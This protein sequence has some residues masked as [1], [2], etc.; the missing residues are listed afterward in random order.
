MN[1]TLSV[2]LSPLL[3]LTGVITQGVLP[4]VHAAVGATSESITASWKS[5]VLQAG[6]KGGLYAAER[7]AYAGAIGWKYTGDFSAVVSANYAPAS[8]IEEGRPARDLKAMLNTSQKVR[9]SKAGKRYLII[10][11]RHTLASMPSAVSGAAISMGPSW[12]TG[13]AF[14]DNGM[15]ASVLRNT[16]HWDKAGDQFKKGKKTY[17]SIGALPAGLAPKLKPSHKTDIYA[18]MRRMDTSSGKSKSSAY[19]T[20]RVMVEGSNG[21]VIPARPGLFIADAVAKNA[22]ASFEANVSEALKVI[23]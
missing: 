18:G 22:E 19:L 23:G 9:M 13:K 12:I 6:G 15:G 20:F 4:A 3:G 17:L 14:Q 21:W 11:L 8:E 2:D 16:Y 5:A 10:P 1:Y 7:D